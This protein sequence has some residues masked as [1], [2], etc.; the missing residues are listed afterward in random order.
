MT[1]EQIARRK[2][3]KAALQWIAAEFYAD[4]NPHDPSGDWSCEMLESDLL[5]AARE[6]VEVS[7]ES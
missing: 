1:P 3:A 4:D 5:D 2:L 6:L 7:N